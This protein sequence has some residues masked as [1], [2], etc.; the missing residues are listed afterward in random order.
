M[1]AVYGPAGIPVYWIINLKAKEVEVY[2]LLKR[3]G[4]LL[5]MESHAFS[6]WGNRCRSWSMAWT[7]GGSPSA[8]LSEASL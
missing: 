3:Q 4:A 7:W 1:A 5:D 2:T 6:S 8:T